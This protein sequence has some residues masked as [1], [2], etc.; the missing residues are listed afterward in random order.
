MFSVPVSLST[1]TEGQPVAGLAVAESALDVVDALLES[2]HNAAAAVALNDWELPLLRSAHLS[3]QMICWPVIDG[4]GRPVALLVGGRFGDRGTINHLLVHPDY[5]N[6]NIGR[7]LARYAVGWF[8][9]YGVRTVHLM[10]ITLEEKNALKFWRDYLGFRPL[11]DRV[12]L[13]CDVPSDVARP[14]SV[15]EL[16]IDEVHAAG[17]LMSGNPETNSARLTEILRNGEGTVLCSGADDEIDGLI[18]AGSLGVR[19]WIEF[20][21]FGN[22]NESALIKGVLSWFANNGIFRVHSFVPVQSR[23]YAALLSNGFHELEGEVTL[24]Y[25]CT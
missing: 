9:E 12:A 16:T 20:A 24:E 17:R 18:I 19:G 5:R 11:V 23:E 15:R 8:T 4:D 10:V 7:H 3:T 13:E 22:S 21:G 1:L 2:E 6:R 25:A 14:D